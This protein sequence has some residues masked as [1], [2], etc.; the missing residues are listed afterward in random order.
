MLNCFKVYQLFIT[1]PLNKKKISPTN[2][3]NT[4]WYNTADKHRLQPSVKRHLLC[5]E[6]ASLNKEN[7]DNIDQYQSSGHI[8]VRDILKKHLEKKLLHNLYS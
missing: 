6:L 8:S 2:L 3:W 1:L 7:S 5:K 4:L